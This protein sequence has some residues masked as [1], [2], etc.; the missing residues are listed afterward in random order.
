MA[1]ALA[2]MEINFINSWSKDVLIDVYKYFYNSLFS[3]SFSGN[4]TPLITK[5]ESLLVA[6]ISEKAVQSFVE[7]RAITF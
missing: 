2:C 5:E 1:F 7:E 4:A 6:K 3:I